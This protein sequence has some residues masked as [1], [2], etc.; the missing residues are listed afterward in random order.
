MK[1]CKEIMVWGGTH[2]N[3]RVPKEIVK[4]LASLNLH[5][6]HTD[7]VLQ[8]D[9]RIPDGYV[10][11]QGVYEIACGRE[12]S[13]ISRLLLQGA[14][15]P[16]VQLA[17]ARE[18]LRKNTSI[19]HVLDLHNANPGAAECVALWPGRRYSR[20]FLG[21]LRHA[22]GLEHVTAWEGGMHAQTDNCAVVELDPTSE[23]AN[24]DFWPDRLEAFVNN[25]T[26]PA[27][28]ADF[29]WWRHHNVTREDAL[30]LGLWGREFQPFEQL[31]EEAWPLVDGQPLHITC[32]DNAGPVW[33]AEVATR[34]PVPRLQYTP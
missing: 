32:Y 1:E 6:V 10:N 15:P 17:R 13:A 11:Q 5:G 2:P 9:E 14:K 4:A 30:K 21:F 18:V 12:P 34:L 16:E 31:P 3:E 29:R 26:P 33:W 24:P 19:G 28:A 22:L 7:I 27:T 23:R 20:K 8:G 25:Q